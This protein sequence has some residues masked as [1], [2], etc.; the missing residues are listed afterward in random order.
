MSGGWDGEDR[1]EQMPPERWRLTKDV[2]IADVLSICLAGAAVLFAYTE[3]SERAALLES[4]VSE[5]RA[6]R[7]DE[8]TALVQRLDRLEDKLDRLIE[9]AGSR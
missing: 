2:S 9:R 8:K 1:R 3:L 4:A 7:Q 6:Q 5:I